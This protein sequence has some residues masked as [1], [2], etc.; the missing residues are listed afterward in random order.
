MENALGLGFPGP[1]CSRELT[2]G[3]LALLPR[4]ADLTRCNSEL[5]D[6]AYLIPHDITTADSSCACIPQFNLDH[7]F[8]ALPGSVTS[9]FGTTKPQV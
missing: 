9:R 4:R 1:R 7:D 5:V 2:P 6:S 8:L 3:C